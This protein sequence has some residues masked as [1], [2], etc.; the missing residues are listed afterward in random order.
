MMAPPTPAVAGKLFNPI[1]EAKNPAC[2]T[3]EEVIRH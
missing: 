3:K 2:P 1:E